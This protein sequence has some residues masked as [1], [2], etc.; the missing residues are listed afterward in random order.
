[1]PMPRPL[2]CC[3]PLLLAVSLIGCRPQTESEPPPAPEPATDAGYENFPAPDFTLPTLD[4]GSFTLSEHRGE[5][6]VLNFW[7]TWCLP[8]LAEMPD[9]EKLH[10]ELGSAG[11]QIVGISQDTESADELLPFAAELGVT[12]PLLLDPAFNV[13]NRYG[14]ISVLPT[15]IIIDR[16]G[17]IAR[18]EYGALTRRMMLALLDGLLDPSPADSTQAGEV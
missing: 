13:S 1:M 14:G 10:R 3:L 9:L 12:Y 4:G 6:V 15:T 16:E 5:V 18:T 8:C 7:A 11:L 2:R 17:R